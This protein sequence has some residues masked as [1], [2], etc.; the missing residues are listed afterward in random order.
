MW[1][2]TPS[3]FR[4]SPTGRACSLDVGAG[5]AD[6]APG[7]STGT[8]T[9]PTARTEATRR[10]ARP[11]LRLPDHREAGRWGFG[12]LGHDLA[13]VARDIDTT[14]DLFGAGGSSCRHGPRGGS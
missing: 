4:K 7:R 5:S 12:E 2:L 1:M 11:A 14:G 3:E 13:P 6:A 9:R 8:P 10:D